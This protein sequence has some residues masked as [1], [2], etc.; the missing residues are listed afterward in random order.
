MLEKSQKPS[1]E[2][3]L[4]KALIDEVERVAKEMKLSE[5][6]KNKLLETVKKF[7][8]KSMLEP[9]EAV[10]I[11]AAQSISEPATQM[12]CAADEKILVKK[13]GKI[14][15]IEIGKFVDELIGKF[16]AIKKDD[17]EILDIPK[18]IDLFV[19]SLNEDEKLEEKRIKSVIRH[20]SPEK[21]LMIK[22]ASGR[23]ITATD[24]H[25][26]VIRNE[27]KIIPISGKQLKIGDR[28]PVVRFLPENCIGE[29]Q[30]SSFF[31]K[32]NLVK[33]YDNVYPYITSS[34]PL[35]NKLQLDSSLGCFIGTYLSEGNCKKY[36]VNI[37][38]KHVNSS[39]LNLLKMAC[40]TGP[41]NKKVPYFAFSAKEDFISAL[42]QA[43]FDND[44]SITLERRGI[45]ATSKSKE[46]IDGITILL[47]R[48]GIFCS[49]SDDG[50]RLWIPYNYADLFL[51][52]IGTSLKERA[53]L[54]KK[55][56]KK[57]RQTKRNAEYSDMIPGIGKLLFSMA[58]KLK[59]P[60]RYVNSFI[61]KQEIGRETLKK[62]LAKFEEIAK[63]K[64]VNMSIEIATL[65]KAVESDVVWDRIEK[66]YYVDS[67]SKYVY[68]ISVDG[69]ETFTTFDGI[70][71]HNTMRTYHFAGSAGIKVTY[72]LPR[73]VEIFD[74]K[75]ELE[76]PVMEIYL[77]KEFNNREKS[78]ELAE[79]IIEKRISDATREVSIN[80][81][82]NS[83]EIEPY[84]LR[85]LNKIA[86]AIKESIPGIKIKEKTKNIVVTTK[87]E[88][89]VKTLQTLREK[90][91]NLHLEGVRGIKNAIVRRE[92]EDW[93][94][95]T[96]G[97]NLEEILKIEEVDETRTITN[98]IHETLKVLG[99]EAARNVIIKE[100]MKTLQEQGLN[101]DVRHIIL[102]GDIMTSTGR[103]QSIGRY[104]VAGT[105][106][107][108]LSRAA[109]EE[110]VKH[111]VRAS[112]RNEV[113]EFKGIFENVMIG[114][115]I[116]SGTGML[117]LIAK[118]EEEEK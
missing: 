114:Q 46:L 112:I 14:T 6:K 22:T 73:L 54:L 75:R 79:S 103:I 59:F 48:F 19:Y 101:V 33:V 44:G 70:V 97:S 55:L 90:I 106:T 100:A 116:P 96:L 26:F 29:I 115:V 18:G 89:D 3:E 45:R 42:L 83:I 5:E 118:F 25:S 32:E 30:V 77:K 2:I 78:R 58:K 35:P 102:V 16:G 8:L 4:P 43:Y 72:G 61:K 13:E 95:N 57:Y 38:K 85:K 67:K 27:N 64:N 37:S 111:L 1:S 93:L 12:S 81:S 50:H 76:T 47:A 31:G 94:I 104:G 11:I 107:S 68:D 21:L 91:L 113:D 87:D 24:H 88:V 28:I 41:D 39:L 92:G 51:E 99:I 109:F 74:A 108:V 117:E 36:F 53:L 52:K 49:K 105:Q 84:D 63:L 98:D 65:K 86:K 9:G 10:G 15:P 80:L 110:T 40:G 23:K 17:S 60:T 71:T 56:G 62:Y 69:L 66:I 7:Y 82:E 20:K 34:K